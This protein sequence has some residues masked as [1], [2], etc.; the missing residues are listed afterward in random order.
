[1]LFRSKDKGLLDQVGGFTYISELTYGI[2]L[3]GQTSTYSRIVAEKSVRR[4]VIKALHSCVSDAYEGGDLRGLLDRANSTLQAASQA[5][6]K[7]EPGRGASLRILRMGDVPRENVSWLWF[8][9]IP[10]RKLTILEGDPG[11]GKSFVMCA[12]AA[13]VSRGQGFP[14]TAPS[15]PRNVLMLSA[16]DGLADTLRPRLD[17]VGADVERVFALDQRLTLDQ[18]GLHLLEENVSKFEPKLV[19]IDPL[20]AYTGSKVD[21]HRANECR[22]ISTALKDIAERQH[23]A[24]VALRHLSK[25]TARTPMSAGLGSIDIRAAARS[26]LLVGADPDDPTQRAVVQTKNNLAPEGGAIGYRIDEGRFRWTGKSMLTA[27]RILAGPSGE[28]ERAGRSEAVD[29][30]RGALAE[31]PRRANEVKAEASELGITEQMLRTARARLGVVSQKRGQPGSARQ[32]WVWSLREEANAGA[33]DVRGSDEQHL[34][35]TSTDKDS[36]PQEL[37]EG[38]GDHVLPPLRESAGTPSTYRPG[39]LDTMSGGLLTKEVRTAHA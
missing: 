23:C 21:I 11:V 12:L 16:E 35:V 26:V 14:D 39:Q 38:V 19:L 6:S 33:E 9:Y 7:S 17:A 15:E 25:A 10:L 29:F 2:P 34:P 3:T 24:I 22:V 8:P 13:S 32:C 27:E 31:G 1:V 28:D 18:A 5:C 37:A 30:L 20:F 4:Q 36:Y